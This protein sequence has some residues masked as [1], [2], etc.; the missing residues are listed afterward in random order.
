[1]STLTDYFNRRSQAAAATAPVMYDNDPDAVYVTAWQI[2]L[3][4]WWT[5]TEQQ[6]AWHRWNVTKAPGFKA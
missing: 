4:E 5:L 6:R 1:M 2:S 3:E